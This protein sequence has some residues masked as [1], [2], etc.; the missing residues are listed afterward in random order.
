[1]DVTDFQSDLT[2][3][4]WAFKSEKND[5]GT[6]I[7]AIKF[8]VPCFQTNQRNSIEKIALGDFQPRR[9]CDL[10]PPGTTGTS[11]ASFSQPGDHVDVHTAHGGWK[12]LF[13]Q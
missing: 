9:V 4:K 8:S 12:L 2:P 1:M 3:S 7:F 11:V 5:A 13:K 6:W 10:N